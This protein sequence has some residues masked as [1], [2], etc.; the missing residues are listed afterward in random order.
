MI[1]IRRLAFLYSRLSVLA[2]CLF[3]WACSFPIYFHIN[4]TYRQTSVESL[5][6]AVNSPM[7]YLDMTCNELESEKSKA[8]CF[9]EKARMKQLAH[10][11]DRAKFIKSL[12]INYG[13]SI[14]SLSPVRLE[15]LNRYTEV[16]YSIF[17]FDILAASGKEQSEKEELS[18]QFKKLVN[19]SKEANEDLLR[20]G[21]TITYPFPLIFWLSMAL[22]NLVLNPKSIKLW[23]E[24]KENIIRNY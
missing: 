10:S 1:L 21:S 8:L 4:D 6:R 23:K 5:Q 14:K 7:S 22:L 20:L 11:E 2:L 17:E 24:E 16:T 12:N 15:E 18:N 19:A 13:D 9:E 3:A